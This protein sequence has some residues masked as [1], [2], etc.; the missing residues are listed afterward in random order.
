M[1]MFTIEV[2]NKVVE[3]NG[4]ETILAVCKR[5]GINVPTLCHM[6]GLPPSGAC[7]L[8]IVELEGEQ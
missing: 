8:C 3:T 2:D 5:E 1:T 7:R 4:G 6:E